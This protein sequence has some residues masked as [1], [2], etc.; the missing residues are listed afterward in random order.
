MASEAKSR[1]AILALLRRANPEP[2]LAALVRA[3]TA[4]DHPAPTIRR[5]PLATKTTERS[6]P[7]RRRRSWVPAVAAI[8][9]LVI[10]G[11]LVFARANPRFVPATSLAC[12]PSTA[13][14]SAT[15]FGVTGWS[16]FES[17]RYCFRIGYPPD[18]FA[19]S[20]RADWTMETDAN[21]WLSASQ[22]SFVSPSADIRVSAWAVPLETAIDDMT[23]VETWI[24]QY[25]DQT[26]YPFCAEAIER[27][28]PL[29]YEPSNCRP[30]G[31]LV[32]FDGVEPAF[33]T[34][35]GVQAIFTGP[36]PIG[37]TA[38]R[39]MVVA[40]WRQDDHPSVAPYGGGQSLLEAFISTLDVWLPRG[41]RTCLE[42]ASY[43]P[44]SC[45]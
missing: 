16:S 1:E 38:D 5:T 37:R 40:V 18:W 39:M 35:E 4:P 36:E 31:L 20:A 13:L 44:G 27:A 3:V 6:T 43:A 14:S 15:E 32:H 26:G 17:E 11:G 8:A 41:E 24:G 23:D 29:C 45:P 2:D 10:V 19:S 22:E 21:N 33:A 28:V 42:G 9:T 25:C 7:A 12:E 34:F 30:A